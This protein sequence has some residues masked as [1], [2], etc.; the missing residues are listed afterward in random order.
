[1]KKTII[2]LAGI[3]A[4][5]C[6]C[7]KI[8]KPA[9]ETVSLKLNFTIGGESP[10]DDGSAETKVHK[11][12]WANNDIVYIIFDEGFSTGGYLKIRYKRSDDS[13]EAVEWSPG[14]EAKIAKKTGGELAALYMPNDK[15]GGTIEIRNIG[16]YC[17]ITAKDRLGDRYYSYWLEAHHV[18]YT[19]SGEVLSANISLNRGGYGH[20]PTQF[21]LPDLDRNGKRIN[22]DGSGQNICKYKL[23][24][25]GGGT[26]VTPYTPS[27]LYWTDSSGFRQVDAYMDAYRMSAYYYQK[28]MFSGY[29]PEGYYKWTFTLTDGTNTY[30][31]TLPENK[32]LHR[33]YTYN[34][35]PLNDTSK[36]IKQ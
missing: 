29:T 18:A 3:A 34:L 9:E 30:K 1:M 25:N 8:E 21:T 16:T 2:L 14:L 13:W 4:M 35:P 36:W 15:V 10:M 12:A 31:Y 7:S 20:G 5:L 27:S 19:V 17:T 22:A 6:A 26:R 11:T 24:A 32:Y 33:G 28:L 23:T